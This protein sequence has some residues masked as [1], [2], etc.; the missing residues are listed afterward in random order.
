[1]WE[2]RRDR[3]DAVS[4]AKDARTALLAA[5][6]QATQVAKVDTWLGGHAVR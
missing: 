4:I 3:A 5:S 1:M 2:T 6:A